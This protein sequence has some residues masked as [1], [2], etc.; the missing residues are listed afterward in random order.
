MSFQRSYLGS[1]IVD[2]L[3]GSEITLVAHQQL[4]DVVARVAIDLLQPLFYVAERVLRHNTLILFLTIQ[5]QM[6]KLVFVIIFVS[7]ED[8][9]QSA[10]TYCRIAC[11]RN[12]TLRIRFIWSF[13]QIFYNNNSKTN[14]IDKVV[15][16]FDRV[17]RVFDRVGRLS[18]D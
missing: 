5:F 18:V 1:G 14:D 12:E 16:I 8:F 9:I 15:C 10:L 17:G 7:P 13:R 2:D 6:V 4:V 11:N 3:L